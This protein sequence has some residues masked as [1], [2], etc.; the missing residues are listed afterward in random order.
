MRMLSSRKGSRR[1]NVRASGIKVDHLLHGPFRTHRLQII[2]ETWVTLLSQKDDCHR[3]TV[4]ES[5]RVASKKHFNKGL[6]IIIQ[7]LKAPKIPLTLL[8]FLFIYISP[9]FSKEAKYNW[10]A[11]AKSEKKWNKRQPSEKIFKFMQ[12]KEGMKIGEIGAGYGRYSVHLSK[13]VG[14]SGLV[15]ANDIA[16]KAINALTARIKK[17]KLTNIIPVKGSLKDP[18]FP[19]KNLDCLF[20]INTY[21][22][23]ENVV[24][25]IGQA[26]TYLSPQGTFA[27]VEHPPEKFAK[28]HSTPRNQLINELKKIGFKLVK[29]DDSLKYDNLYLFQRR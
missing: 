22:H 17:E 5:P 19:E 9:S 6:K 3:L 4:D 20:I 26:A 1:K 16:P 25:Y 29:E 15:Y 11:L 10:D 13:Q 23:I 24:T 18:L 7:Y 21:H 8:I 27:I 28:A 14:K 12:I 2:P